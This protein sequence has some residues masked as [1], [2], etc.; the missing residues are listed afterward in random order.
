[1]SGLKEWDKYSA[2]KRAPKLAADEGRRRSE[3]SYAFQG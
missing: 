2:A 3:Q 1:M